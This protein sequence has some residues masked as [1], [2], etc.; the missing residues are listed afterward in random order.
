MPEQLY[1]HYFVR[2][3]DR[4]DLAGEVYVRIYDLDEHNRARV[5]SGDRIMFADG[6][7][8][9]CPFEFIALVRRADLVASVQV[10]PH[11]AYAV[12]SR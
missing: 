7:E 11:V 12:E 10:Q 3:P 2:F 4:P 9:E 6:L 5:L 1:A 8:S